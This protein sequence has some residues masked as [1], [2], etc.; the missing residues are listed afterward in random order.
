MKDFDPARYAE[1]AAQ[2]VDL[3]LPEHCRSGVAANLARLA[4]MA[5]SLFEFA[6]PE[7]GARRTDP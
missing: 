4:A 3:P 5:Q 6:L 1:A 7:D 2:A